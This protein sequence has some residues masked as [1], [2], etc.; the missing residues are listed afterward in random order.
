MRAAFSLLIFLPAIALAD[1]ATGAHGA[2]ATASADASQAALDVLKRGGTAA[3]AAVAATLVLAVT[4][5][6]SCGIGGGGFALIYDAKKKEIRALD[7]RERAPVLAHQKLYTRDGKVQPELA[8]TGALAV[9]TP[10]EIAGLYA[11]HQ[12]YGKRPMGELFDDAIRLASKGFAVSSRLGGAFDYRAEQLA[13]FD[14]T[15]NAWSKGGKWPQTGDKWVQPDLAKS[16]KL[17]QSKGEPAFYKGD[18][19]KKLVTTVTNYGGVLAL[20]DLAEYQ[21]R[22]LDPVS[23]TYRGYQVYSMPPPSSGGVVLAE[24]LNMME[25]IDVAKNGYRSAE[26]IHVA[27]EAMRRAY[28]DRASYLGDPQFVS[29]PVAGLMSKDYAK[30]LFATIKAGASTSADVKPGHPQGASE[31]T[32]TTHLSIV[33]AEGN[34]VVLTTTVNGP[35]GSSLVADG[36]GIMLNN[37]MDDFAIAPGVANQFGL[38]GSDANAVNPRKTPLSSMTPTL[39]LK[40]GHLVYGIGSPG[41]PTIITTA[42][43]MALALLDYHTDLATAVAMPRIHEQWQPD[44]VMVERFGLDVATTKALTDMGYTLEASP[45]WGNAQAIGIVDGKR[46]SASD[47]RGEGRALAY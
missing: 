35:F 12:K 7:F 44:K 2:V 21:V 34:A 40:D 13:H 9:G 24:L 23:T 25:Q 36:T 6:Q 42:F 29:V 41:G 3:D 31:P 1:Q 32:H 19:A 15:K 30:Q 28:A 20:T 43:W 8:Q 18:L 14:A 46:V 4:E 22:W 5:P 45:P 38:V 11:L 10:G 16:L 27:I 39:I 17:I 37:E 47:P 33:D 26:T